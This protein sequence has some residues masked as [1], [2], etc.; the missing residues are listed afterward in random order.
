MWWPLAIQCILS[1]CGPRGTEIYDSCLH[2][3]FWIQNSVE[4]LTKMYGCLC[5]AQPTERLYIS[6]H[7]NDKC[8]THNEL[9]IIH[10][11]SIAL[12]KTVWM[13]SNGYTKEHGEIFKLFSL[14]F[15]ITLLQNHFSLVGTLTSN[16]CA[17]VIQEPS[18]GYNVKL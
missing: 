17:C 10:P 6:A 1:W 4:L 13:L 11:H 8:Q 7:Q 15:T 14:R 2:N 5:V 16:C 18:E 12:R 9:H 3:Q